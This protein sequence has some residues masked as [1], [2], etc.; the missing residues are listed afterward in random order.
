MLYLVSGGIFGRQMAQSK[1]RFR[2]MGT[3]LVRFGSYRAV[4]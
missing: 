3:E 2:L 4:H 1:S